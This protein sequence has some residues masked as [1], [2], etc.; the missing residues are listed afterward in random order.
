MGSRGSK[1]RKPKQRLPSLKRLRIVPRNAEPPIMW[2]DAG[3]GFEA[4]PFSPAGTAQRGWWLSQALLRRDV[5][6]SR[7]Q[8]M[9]RRAGFVMVVLVVLVLVWSAIAA[10]V[11]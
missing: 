11:H 6:R 8:Q 7:P 5:A 10:L 9:M 2:P 1:R 3:S 4:D